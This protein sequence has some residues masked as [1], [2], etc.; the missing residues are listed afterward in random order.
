[1]PG[2]CTCRHSEILLFLSSRAWL[3]GVRRG[4]VYAPGLHEL[5][6]P[7]WLDRDALCRGSTAGCRSCCTATCVSRH[8]WLGERTEGS[9]V[10][11]F[12]STV[13]STQRRLRVWESEATHPRP[14]LASAGTRACGAVSQ[15][16]QLAFFF[17]SR[18]H[19]CARRANVVN[20]REVAVQPAPVLLQSY[21]RG[22]A[23][24]CCTRS[25]DRP[26]ERL[27]GE[28]MDRCSA[29]GQPPSS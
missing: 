12:F 6:R 19:E 21:E 20:Q 29:T 4:E 7:I 24:I 22:V 25:A 28:Q 26:R 11:H 5:V 14:C 16:S 9:A 10:F 3:E 2:T 13:R 17:H 27:R 23:A 1:M 18:A 15:F 8:G